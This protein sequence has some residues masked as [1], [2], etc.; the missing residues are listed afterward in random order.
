MSAQLV[1]H[2]FPSGH[3]CLNLVS[4]AAVARLLWMVGKIP[5][6]WCTDPCATFVWY[7]WHIEA[8]V[9]RRVAEDVYGRLPTSV[10]Q[11]DLLQEHLA[12]EDDAP[13]ALTELFEVTL[14]DVALRH[15]AHVVLVKGDVEVGE[16]ALFICQRHNAGRYDLLLRCCLTRGGPPGVE[17]DVERVCI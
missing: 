11:V 4:I 9:L 2:I 14:G 8:V 10:H 17:R 3:N 12:E 1:D 16:L 15:P 13:V 6:A 7:H 5:A